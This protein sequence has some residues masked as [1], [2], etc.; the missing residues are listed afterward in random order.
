MERFFKNLQS[1]NIDFVTNTNIFYALPNNFS[2]YEDDDGGSIHSLASTNASSLSS[3]SSAASL[4]SDH[5]TSKYSRRN[6][7]DATSPTEKP[8]IPQIRCRNTINNQVDA[9]K[10]PEAMRRAPPT[11][12]ARRFKSSTPSI[13][14]NDSNGHAVTNGKYIANILDVRNGGG[15]G[16]PPKTDEHH[17]N[18]LIRSPV[19]S[20]KILNNLNVL[21]TN[22]FAS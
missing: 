11:P 18:G 3:S 13:A 10:T 19:K 20:V 5:P 8:V 16:D 2:K 1:F 14:A 6:R 4:I 9:K 7:L 22:T 21:K 17:L 15:V 12:T